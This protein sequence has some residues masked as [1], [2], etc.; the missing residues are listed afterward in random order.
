MLKKLIIIGLIIGL[1]GCANSTNAPQLTP[2]ART[3]FNLT[4]LVD[5]LGA[6]QLAAEN[7]SKTVDPKTNKTILSVNSARTIV[8]FTVVANTTIGQTPNGWYATV[9]TGYNAAKA[10]LSIDELTKFQPYLNT[11][12]LVLAAGAP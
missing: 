9:S 6:L 4:K 7:A 11:F 10:S 5:A 12:E 8:Q 3:E 1:N 2:V